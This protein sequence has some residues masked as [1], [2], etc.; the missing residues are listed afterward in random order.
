M[1]FK[2]TDE[3]T[4]LPVAMK[5]IQAAYLVIPYF[6]DIYLYL[7]QIKLPNTRTALQK[8]NMLLE[9]I[10]ILL[11]SLLFKNVSNQEKETV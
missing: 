6:K 11:D 2:N 7:A 3:G 5:E 10:Y 1:V 4:H 9:N 8:V